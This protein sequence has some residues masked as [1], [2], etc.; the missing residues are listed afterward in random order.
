MKFS[1]IQ[2]HMSISFDVI[3]DSLS[4]GA[5]FFLNIETVNFVRK[6]FLFICYRIL[7]CLRFNY[8]LQLR[9]INCFRMK[10]RFVRLRTIK[11]QST[12]RLNSEANIVHGIFTLILINFVAFNVSRTISLILEIVQILDMSYTSDTRIYSASQIA[13]ITKKIYLKYLS[14][15]VRPVG[16]LLLAVCCV[17]C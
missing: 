1:F 16:N 12:D 3:L 10:S 14:V 4:D 17:C 15:P 2:G 5:T 9:L 11:S 13:D 8:L 7:R 6:E